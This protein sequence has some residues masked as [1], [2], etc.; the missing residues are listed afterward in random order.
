MSKKQMEKNLEYG[1][2]FNFFG[3]LFSCFTEACGLEKVV[4]K[5]LDEEL[6]NN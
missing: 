6:K 4:E 3:T 5:K 2:C 1:D